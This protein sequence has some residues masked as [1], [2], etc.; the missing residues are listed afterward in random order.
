MPM[1]SL[2]LLERKKR[3]ATNRL[4]AELPARRQL[5]RALCCLER[6]LPPR[7]TQMAPPHSGRLRARRPHRLHTR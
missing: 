4:L 3:R 6:C 1:A 7:Q 2:Q 5:Q